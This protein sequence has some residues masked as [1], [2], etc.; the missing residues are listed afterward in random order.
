[1]VADRHGE[2]WPRR[3][4]P[5]LLLTLGIGPRPWRLWRRFAA[6]LVTGIRTWP[7]SLSIAPESHRSRMSHRPPSSLLAATLKTPGLFVGPKQ[8]AKAFST[9]QGAFQ[10]LSNRP[11][12]FYLMFDGPI[13]GLNSQIGWIRFH[14]PE[15]IRTSSQSSWLTIFCTRKYRF[16]TMAS[17]VLVM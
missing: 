7:H 12:P 14:R 3:H 8:S 17:L 5:L 6:G 15:E 11:Q 13:R 1:V 10:S 9:P 4:H 16:H 2:V